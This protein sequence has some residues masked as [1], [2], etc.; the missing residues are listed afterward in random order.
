[1][2][3]PSKKREVKEPDLWCECECAN[4]EIGTHE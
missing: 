1:M 4:C 3:K 2:A